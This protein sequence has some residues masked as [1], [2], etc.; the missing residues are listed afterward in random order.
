METAILV[1]GSKDVIPIRKG[2]APCLCPLAGSVLN[3]ALMLMGGGGRI[4]WGKA[5]LEVFLS[6][7]F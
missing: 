4:V 3:R 1:V 7:G 5:A 6:Y 2:P